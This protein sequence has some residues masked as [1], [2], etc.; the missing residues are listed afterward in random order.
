LHHEH[1]SLALAQRCSGVEAPAPLFTSLL[2]YRHSDARRRSRTA[3]SKTPATVPRDAMGG[4]RRI[5]GEERTNYPLTMSVDDLGEGFRLKAQVV[6]QWLDPAR[7]CAMMHRALEGLAEAL[8]R[9][10]DRSLAGVDVLPAGE[11][12]QLVDEWSRTS[13]PRPLD[14]LVHELFEARAEHMPD[15]VAVEHEGERLT[16]AELNSRANRLAHYLIER[17]V[18]PDVRVGLVASRSPLLVEA[19]LAILKAGGAYVPLDPEHPIERIRDMLEDSSPVVVLTR[20]SSAADL[21]DT[22]PTVMSLDAE[23]TSWVGHPETN[24]VV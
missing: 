23:S 18:G 10:P 15:A 21:A 13:A 5:H 17:G 22:A 7:V 11:R 4:I 9:S 6:G 19:E 14:S 20:S 12:R 1:A 8:E 3:G 16:Y 24:P 2:N